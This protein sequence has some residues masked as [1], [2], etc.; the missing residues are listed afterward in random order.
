MAVDS[1]GNDEKK[2]KRGVLEVRDWPI[3]T[4]A[5]FK[6][7]KQKLTQSAEAGKEGGSDWIY[8]EL[9]VMAF[10]LVGK[11]IPLGA[12]CMLFLLRINVKWCFSVQHIRGYI[13]FSCQ[14]WNYSE[15]S[16]TQAGI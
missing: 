4:V 1:S 9:H 5:K 7:L 8:A 6:Y 15:N 13:L 10:P 12:K 2:R 14:R 11:I 3:E 16:S